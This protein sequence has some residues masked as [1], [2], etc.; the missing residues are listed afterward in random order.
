MYKYALCI[1][2]IPTLSFNVANIIKAIYGKNKKAFV[3]D[4]D[5]TLWG[6]VVGDDGPENLEIGKETAEGEAYLAF[7]EYLKAHKDIG[8][9]LNV[10]SK[11]EEDNALAGLNHKDGALKP[12]DFTVIK[13]NWEPKSSN[14]DAI[15]IELSLGADSFVFVDDNPAER[16]IVEANI[17][18][19]S[20]PAISTPDK[21]MRD[22]DRHGYFE[23]LKLSKDDLS[24]NEMYKAN[25]KRAIEG[26]YEL[27]RLFKVSG[28]E[29]SYKTLRACLYGPHRTAYQQEQSI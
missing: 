9:L 7:Q 11:N 18:G 6:G 22:I 1:Q 26:I 27:W 8:V 15:A 5:N 17:K 2:A 4:L 14:V 16:E 13:A 24:R 12:D 10:S 3:L 25:I 20:V 23:V 29:S 21:Y 19:I 28:D